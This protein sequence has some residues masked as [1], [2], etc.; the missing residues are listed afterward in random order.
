MFLSGFLN[1]TPTGTFSPPGISR[2]EVA[3]CESVVVAVV[4]VVGVG[5]GVGDCGGW[6]FGLKRDCGGGG[7]WPA[8]LASSTRR[9]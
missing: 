6:R 9:S 3:G 2:S 4:V 7:S 8:A 5:I 1:F